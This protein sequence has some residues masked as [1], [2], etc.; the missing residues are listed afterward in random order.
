MIKSTSGGLFIF[1]NSNICSKHG[2]S[3][4]FSRRAGGTRITLSSTVIQSAKQTVNINSVYSW[5]TKTNPQYMIYHHKGHKETVLSK[6]LSFQ[7]SLFIN[8]HHNHW[9]MINSHITIRVTHFESQIATRSWRS[10][11]SRRSICSLGEENV[12]TCDFTWKLHCLCLSL[13]VSTHK[14]MHLLKNTHT[15]KLTGNP[16]VPGNPLSPFRGTMSIRPPGSPCRTKK[17]S[18]WFG[19]THIYIA[20]L[21]D[22]Y[23]HVKAS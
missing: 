21:F 1:Y 6:S 10:D 11:R 14:H 19:R 3:Y 22:S 4:F 16:G 17:Q 13:S 15:N 7:Y 18:K 12:C 8:C 9:R 20:R 5:L 2:Q 23:L